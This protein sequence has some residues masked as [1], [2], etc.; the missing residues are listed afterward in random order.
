ML[1]T[2]CGVKPPPHQTNISK[3]TFQQPCLTPLRNSKLRTLT[4]TGGGDYYVA[5]DLYFPDRSPI[6]RLYDPV[7]PGARD[8]GPYDGI[9]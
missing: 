9:L 6:V 5:N 3:S 1:A 7:Q 2:G 8:E 4:A